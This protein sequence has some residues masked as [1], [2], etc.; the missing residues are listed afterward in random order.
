MIYGLQNQRNNATTNRPSM[1]ITILMDQQA[2]IGIN[3]NMSD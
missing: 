3:D 2:Q 1:A